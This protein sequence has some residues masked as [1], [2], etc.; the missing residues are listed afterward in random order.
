MSVYHPE[1]Y[2]RIFELNFRQGL[3]NAEIAKLLNITESAVKKQKAQMLELFRKDLIKKTGDHF[4]TAMIL[5]QW[6]KWLT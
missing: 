3:K 1:K 4:L 6:M 2:R 5:L